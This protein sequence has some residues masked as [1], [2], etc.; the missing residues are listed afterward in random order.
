MPIHIDNIVA[1]SKPLDEKIFE[2]LAANP[3][4][5]YTLEEIKATL[6]EFQGF[7]V[8]ASKVNPGM[9]LAGFLADVAFARELGAI[10]RKREEEIATALATLVDANRIR[11][12]NYLGTLRFGVTKALPSWIDQPKLS[13]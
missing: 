1:T 2:V 11:C 12:V 10:Q 7:T 3:D 8:L 4:Q 13:V 5:F 6:G 9:M